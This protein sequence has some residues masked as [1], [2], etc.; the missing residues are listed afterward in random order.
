[1]GTRTHTTF[2]STAA[3]HRLRESVQAL[4]DDWEHR[5]R[6]IDTDTNK[7]GRDR[8]TALVLAADRLNDR[9]DA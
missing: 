4:V 5:S 2:F 8:L 7:A 3:T 1:M 6:F 9:A